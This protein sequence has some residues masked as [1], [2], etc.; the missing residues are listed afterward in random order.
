M[1]C[2]MAWEGAW[3]VSLRDFP[4]IKGLRIV[5]YEKILLFHSHMTAFYPVLFIKHF[6]HI[7]R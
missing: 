2:S 7:L 3:E 1:K 6:A 5:Q 4:E